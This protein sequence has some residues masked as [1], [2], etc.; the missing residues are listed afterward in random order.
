MKGNPLEAAF[1]PKEDGRKY[2]RGYNFDRNDGAG[3]AKEGS[4]INDLIEFFLEEERI[5]CLKP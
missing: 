5:L 4:W 3:M 1:P 2:Y